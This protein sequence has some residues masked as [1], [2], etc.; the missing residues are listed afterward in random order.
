[1]SDSSSESSD[2]S[3][4]APSK[5]ALVDK[6]NRG[7][8][9]NRV[10]N[11]QKVNSNRFQ[12]PQ[13]KIPEP[14]I[15]N[16]NSSKFFEKESDKP[17]LKF[18]ENI[19]RADSEDFHNLEINSNPSN[20]YRPGIQPERN[21]LFSGQSKNIIVGEPPSLTG[22]KKNDIK[23]VIKNSVSSIKN[24]NNPQ[25]SEYSKNNEKELLGSNKGIFLPLPSNNKNNPPINSVNNTQNVLISPQPFLNKNNPPSLLS[26]N[27]P[28]SLQSGNNPPS[29]SNN[30][31]PPI[32]EP[33]SI[34]KNG[35]DI[36]PPTI[37]FAQK[38]EEK[39]SYENKPNFANNKEPPSI[40]KNSG[41]S[42]SKNSF[43]ISKE[44]GREKQKNFKQPD[45]NSPSTSINLNPENLKV[46]ISRASS[47]QSS[48]KNSEN[49]TVPATIKIPLVEKKKIKKVEPSDL[50]NLLDTITKSV[51]PLI[52][53]NKFIQNYDEIHS[54]LIKII[55]SGNKTAMVVLDFLKNKLKCSYCN[56]N[57]GLIELNCDHV[58]C[59][60]C[61]SYKLIP[62]GAQTENSF[63]K[64]LCPICSAA[65]TEKELLQLFPRE[66]RNFR[67][68]IEKTL[69]R[70][71]LNSG[72][73]CKKCLK[74]KKDFIEGACFHMCVDC[75]ADTLRKR[76]FICEFCKLDYQD[77]FD[78]CNL[79]Q[80]CEA[81]NE[82]LYYV[83]NYMK[84]LND[85]HLL[86][87][88]CLNISMIQGK[89]KKCEK[90]L[91]KVEKIEIENFLF[92]HCEQCNRENFR[93]EFV[94]S[95]C[96]SFSVCRDCKEIKDCPNCRSEI[97]EWV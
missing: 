84:T 28:P 36:K 55:D 68:E 31:P 42:S 77:F 70:K 90:K 33:L 96:C 87:S 26:G 7:G 14:G 44:S 10:S 39:K 54:E 40:L 11:I 75:V 8:F 60:N 64:L 86:C 16:P 12:S 5:N 76:N 69:L 24:P 85:G 21:D 66:K 57:N 58:L 9:A 27:N 73:F 46:N 93:G 59:N 51:L 61:F 72:V 30:I 91:S 63:V 65:L 15:N 20:N 88:H 41:L 32:N 17:D 43:L 37:P 29:L 67:N 48:F 4:V 35:P 94:F 19:P 50:V 74:L 52:D 89:C 45:L 78:L 71:S 3:Y 34:K 13:A 6:N 23:P 22:D 83:G 62:D 53:F 38:V 25:I 79:R 47:N 80:N 18:S 81:C 95:T 97:N 92:K 49:L 1:M 82:S 2:D 56:K